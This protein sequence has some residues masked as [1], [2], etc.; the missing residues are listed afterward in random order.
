MINIKLQ[1]WV[2]EVAL[3]KTEITKQKFMSAQFVEDPPNQKYAAYQSLNQEDQYESNDY[4][5]D[6]YD[7]TP[8]YDSLKFELFKP[9]SSQS[10]IEIHQGNPVLFFSIIGSALFLF[11]C[12]TGVF[13][14][15]KKQK[16]IK[17]LLVNTNT[18]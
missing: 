15:M 5:T 13:Y 11:A 7:E 18:K 16:R 17:Q 3:L 12:L 2:G 14:Y 6:Q 4:D 10:G 9:T 1:G 8:S